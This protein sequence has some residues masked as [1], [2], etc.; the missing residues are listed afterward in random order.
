MMQDGKYIRPECLGEWR[1][2]LYRAQNFFKHAD[3][4]STNTLFSRRR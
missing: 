2:I 3:D 4:D 1:K